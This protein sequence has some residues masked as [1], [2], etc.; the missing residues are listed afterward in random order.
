M[1]KDG[2][3][4]GGIRIGAGRPKQN[5]SENNLIEFPAP[6]I[7]KLQGADIP[8]PKKYLSAKQC[9]DNKKNY[10]VQIYKETYQWLKACKCEHLVTQQQIENFAQ[11]TARQIQC[12]EAINKYGFLSQH[13]TTNAAIASPFVK[14]SL[15]YMRQSTN[16]WLQI[17]NVVKQNYSGTY[18]NGSADDSMEKLL[19]KIRRVK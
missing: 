10:A 6:E 2:T 18:K 11:I 17:Y 1:A 3:L 5:F 12:E 16:L 14:M 13:P 15:D 19:G 7:V 8:P 4:R 9:E